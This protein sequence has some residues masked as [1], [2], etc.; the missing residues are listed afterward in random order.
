MYLWT[1]SWLLSVHSPPHIYIYIY[2]VDYADDHH[3]LE[4]LRR[5]TKLTAGIA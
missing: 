5:K 2:V 1:S 4:N 3:S